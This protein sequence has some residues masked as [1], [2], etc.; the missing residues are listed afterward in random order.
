MMEL[1]LSTRKERIGWYFYDWANSAFYTTV[2]TVFLGPY[3]TSV[4]EAAATAIAPGNKM[5]Q[6]F[7]IHVHSGSFFPYVLSLSVVL[8]VFLLPFLG[9]VADYSHRKKQLLGIFAYIGAFATMGLYF[10]EGTNYMLGGALFIIANLSFGS[11][12]VMY[13]AYLNDIAEPENRN[14][15]SSVGWAVG[16]LGGGLILALNLVFYTFRE[17]L[18]VDTSLAVRICLAS[19]GLWW[20]LFTLMPMMTLKVRRSFKEIPGKSSVFS[21]GFKELFSTLKEARKYPRTFLYLAA[22]LLYNDGVQAVIGLTAVFAVEE[23]KISQDFLIQVILL[24]QFVAFLGSLLFNL[25]AKILNTK[26]TL[27][28]SIVVWTAV[29]FYSYQYLPAYA[30]MQFL[31]LSVIIGLVLG[32]TQALSR[33]LYS[34][35]IPK[36]REAQYY[37]L[38][39][40]SERGTSWLAPLLF[41]L[42]LQYSD[43]YRMAVLSIAVFFIAGFMLLMAVDVKRTIAEAGNEYEGHV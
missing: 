1:K 38:Y 7:G 26:R 32:G 11:S 40:I 36:S 27:L 9:A 10:L 25:A 17:D 35:F 29:V 14:S 33:S 6:V 13:N 16:Y 41:G 37:S 18:G 31:I 39:E 24:V 19:A 43:S 12:V 30:E 15:V 5:I 8:Q 21:I 42:A 4:A 28:L 20:A 22:Y 2:I 34:L 3:L 23:L